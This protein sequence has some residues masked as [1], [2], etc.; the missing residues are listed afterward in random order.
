[1]EML[2]NDA[3]KNPTSLGVDRDT[4]KNTLQIDENIMNFNIF[5]LE[6]KGLIKLMHSMGAPWSFAK[7]TAFGIDVAENRDRYREQFPFIQANIQQIH[8]NVYGQV[9]Q[10][11]GS[12]VTFSQQV[13]NAFNQAYQFIQNKTEIQP[14]LREEIK[15]KLQVLEEELKKEEP[16]LGKIQEIWKWLKQN[17][18]W[19]VPMIAHIV[20]EGTKMA[21]GK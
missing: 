17:A 13:S 9:V 11:V 12:E 3:L 15:N 19:I 5:Y 18:S 21:L 4:M 14:E 6:E 8:G 1:M 7:I 10:A 2:Y 20:L 16:N